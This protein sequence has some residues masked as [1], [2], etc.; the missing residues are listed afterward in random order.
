MHGGQILEARLAAQQRVERVVAQEL[1]RERQP[2]AGRA[3]PAPGRRQRPDLAGPQ[4]QPAGVER[5]AER[6]PHLVVA[7]PAQIQHGGLGREQL[8]RALQPG[9]RSRS[10]APPGRSRRPRPPAARSRHPAPPP[11]PPATRSHVDQ[12]DLDRREA[13]EQPRDAAADHPGA[14]DGDPVADQR[15]RVPQRVDRGLDGPRQDR[16]GQRNVI[17]HHGHRARRHDVG[18]L[19]RIE[20]E[21]RA[22]AQLR[23]PLLDGADAQVAVLDRPGELSLLERRPRW[24]RAAEGERLRA[25]A[26]AG[27]QRADDHVIAPRLGQRDRPDLPEPGGAE[28]EGVRVRHG[29]VAVRARTGIGSI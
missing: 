5:A 3:P 18:R 6:E 13:R 21:D 27:A 1:E 26:D 10:C 25:T 7:V 12:R 19:V 4:P 16:P 8:E 11:R 29:R 23:R 24:H 28:P 20:A 14:D 17:G 22:A 15:R 9:R 2:V